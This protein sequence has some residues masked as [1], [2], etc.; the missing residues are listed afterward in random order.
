MREIVQKA[1]DDPTF[2]NTVLCKE[3]DLPQTEVVSWLPYEAVVNETVLPMEALE[4]SYC[5]AGV[6]LSAVRDLTSV[7]LLIRRPNDSNIYLL[8]HC[9]IPQ[10]KIDDL[11]RDG[12]YEAPY[13]LWA[14]QG[15][16]TINEGA[17]VDDMH[18][19]TIINPK[20][21]ASQRDQHQ[22]TAR[23]TR[24]PTSTESRHNAQQN[25]GRNV[26]DNT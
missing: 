26:Y 12:S 10:A 20:E 1:K 14:Q 6:D 17:Q 11:E 15:W 16:L 5:I 7:S 4:H 8:N 23:H 9:F 24:S 21:T 22:R 13:K 2:K 19:Q 18:S 3:F 25:S